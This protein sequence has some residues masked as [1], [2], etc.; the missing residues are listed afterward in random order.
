MA[1]LPRETYH[2][3]PAIQ[4]LGIK[5]IQ[6][7]IDGRVLP[8]AIFRQVHLRTPD[9]EIMSP[10]YNNKSKT[11]KGHFYFFETVFFSSYS[12]TAINNAQNETIK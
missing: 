4:I 2:I 9:T 3:R 7:H 8:A 11:Q 1:S 10:T 12:F 6:W 5:Y